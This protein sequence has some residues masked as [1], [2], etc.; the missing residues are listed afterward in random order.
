[1]EVPLLISTDIEPSL[2][3]FQGEPSPPTLSGRLENTAS[4]ASTVTPFPPTNTESAP[5][6]R[7]SWLLAELAP[8]VSA[9][10]KPPLA[11]SEKE[12]SRPTSSTW[13]KNLEATAKIASVAPQANSE[14]AVMQPLEAKRLLSETLPLDSTDT[15]PQPFI[16]ENESSP[17]FRSGQPD[18]AEP[19]AE[20]VAA[21]PL[22]E[23]EDARPQQ[24]ESLLADLPPSRSFFERKPS[25]AIFSG[26]VDNVGPAVETVAA[27]P[28]LTP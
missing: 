4:T 25:P 12:P 14:S 1:M 16:F 9:N 23:A 2:P 5:R 6:Q 24:G 10:P 11:T 19:A 3:N 26:E 7:L 15:E 28:P 13:L 22:P 18:H 8:M 20:I 21:A 27:T 17:I